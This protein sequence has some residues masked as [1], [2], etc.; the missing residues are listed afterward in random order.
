MSQPHM[1]DAGLLVPHACQC[2]LTDR[3]TAWAGKDAFRDTRNGFGH[4]LTIL[5]N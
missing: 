2:M 1:N 3:P 5:K 4:M